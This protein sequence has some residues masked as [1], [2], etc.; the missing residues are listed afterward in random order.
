MDFPRQA[1]LAC[2]QYS[3][4]APERTIVQLSPNVSDGLQSTSTLRRSFG[5]YWGPQSEN[6]LSRVTICCP[7]I[8]SHNKVVQKKP[9]WLIEH[10]IKLCHSSKV[11]E[12]SCICASG[13]WL[14]STSSEGPPQ[15]LANKPHSFL[16][17]DHAGR[18][19]C[20]NSIVGPAKFTA[21]GEPQHFDPSKSQNLAHI[22]QD[23]PSRAAPS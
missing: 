5:P 7:Y 18:A 15:L 1:R 9:S 23:I 3:S 17:V 14:S 2:A 4:P 6:A 13:P 11:I 12:T 22:K 16:L 20:L 21:K 10:L 19:H 8:L